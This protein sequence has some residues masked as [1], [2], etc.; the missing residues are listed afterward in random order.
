MP[1]IISQNVRKHFCVRMVAAGGVVVQSDFI[2][3]AA[4]FQ[5]QVPAQRR[6]ITRG[7]LKIKLKNEVHDLCLQKDGIDII[8]LF[9][10]ISTTKQDIIKQTIR[11]V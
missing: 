10:P 11:R 1:L 5:F 3:M 7:P 4:A 9:L 2:P 6:R 8:F